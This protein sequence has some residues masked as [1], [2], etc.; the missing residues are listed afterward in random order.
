[1]TATKRKFLIRRLAGSAVVAVLLGIGLARAFGGSSPPPAPD[2]AATLVP[3][4]A[5]VYLNLGTDRQG[6]QW[7]RAAGAV[8]KLPLVGQLRDLLVV[9]AT[10]DTL[11]RMTLARDVEPWLGDE[12]AYAELPGR[13]QR[14]LVLSVRRPAAARRAFG[15]AAGSSAPETYRGALLRDVGGGS[16]AGLSGG[17]ALV[18]ARD[19]VRAALDTRAKPA[20][21]LGASRD[22][23]DLTGG[24]PPERVGNAWLSQEWLSAHAPGPAALLAGAARAAGLQSAAVGFGD[25]GKRIRL[26]VRGRAAAGLGSAAGCSG[27]TRN[28]QDLTSRAPA[29]PAMFMAL[30]GAEC[31]VRNLMASPTS[32]AGA[33]LRWFAAQARKVGVNL[34]REVLPLLG[35]E[36][37]LSVTPGPAVTLDIGGVPAQQGLGVLGRLQPALVNMLK[38]E[39][40]G[41]TAGFAAQTVHGVTALTADLTPALQLSYAALE[42]D[43]LIST[44]VEGI[45]AVKNGQHLDQSNDFKLVLGDRPK[46]S[47]AVLF[48]D[49]QKLL[50]LADQAGLGS[51]PSYAAVRDDLRKIG[52]AGAVLAREGNNI[53]AELRLKN[54]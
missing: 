49:L 6:T 52:A 24:L 38:P 8:S 21:S 20:G 18:G 48:F 14:L 22:Y 19:A 41:A 26:A 37:A 30:A 44:S 33:A 15:R 3:A 39:S 23:R 50:A 27:A 31:A 25:D 1:V 40:A 35:G 9:S 28:G 12:A 46:S 43:L 47:T 45:T 11:G 51:N 42:G 13:A 7:K 17:F 16:V 10:T 29:R 4:N 54:P 32:R 2:R 36:S 34:D 5:L 53:D